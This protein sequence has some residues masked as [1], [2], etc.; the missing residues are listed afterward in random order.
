MAYNN[1]GALMPTGQRQQAH[2]G[3]RHGHPSETGSCGGL[4]QPGINYANLG[5][6]QRAI[7]DFDTTIR[8]KPDHANAYTNRGTAYANLGQN[9]RAIQDFDT[10]IRLKPDHANAYNNRGAAYD[11]LGQKQRAIQDYDTAIRLKPDLAMAYCNRGMLM[12]T[13]GAPEG[14]RDTIRPSA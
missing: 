9:Q 6:N 8:L 5:Q 7:Q 10:T 1:R 14:H 3:L 13:W 12:P 2:S 4:L 11:D